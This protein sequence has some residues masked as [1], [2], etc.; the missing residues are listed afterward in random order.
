MYKKGKFR[1]LAGK[2]GARQASSL[3]NTIQYVQSRVQLT[4]CTALFGIAWCILTV[5]ISF[6]N[7]SFQNW[8]KN[9]KSTVLLLQPYFLQCWQSQHLVSLHQ[10]TL[11]QIKLVHGSLTHLILQIKY[12]IHKRVMCIAW[13]Q[14]GMKNCHNRLNTAWPSINLVN[15]IIHGE[16][17]CCFWVNDRAMDNY[18][19][20]NVSKA[21]LDPLRCSFKIGL[22]GQTNCRIADFFSIFCNLHG[23]FNWVPL[24]LKTRL[25]QV[26]SYKASWLKIYLLFSN[27]A[28][29]HFNFQTHDYK[30]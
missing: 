13:W 25:F 4:N 8:K 24:C 27:A 6:Q 10:L 29:C 1:K 18:D 28:K 21:K 19:L 2:R 15:R 9:M 30:R 22:N 16:S 11:R 20:C 5:V 14:H 12:P 23:S 17:F 7:C 26:W 3:L